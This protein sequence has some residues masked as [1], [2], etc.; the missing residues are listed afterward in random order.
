[1]NMK[2]SI[3]AAIAALGLGFGASAATGDIFS[4]APCD[5]L[6]VNL[7]DPY[8]TYD[9][10]VGA[11][12]EL[13]FKITLGAHKANGE[14][15]RLTYTGLGSEKWDEVYNPLQIGIFVS[16]R[17]QYASL[18][19]FRRGAGDQTTEMV[20][21]YVT[22]SGDFAMPI[23]LAAYDGA[24][25]AAVPVRE[26]MS[27]ASYYYLNPLN[28]DDWKVTFNNS[29]TPA[30]ATETIQCT[31]QPAAVSSFMPPPG[32]RPRLHSDSLASA[33][34]YVKTI[35][36]SD[37]AETPEFWRTI[38]E[39]STI[40]GGGV[41]PKLAIDAAPEVETSVYV[42]S[43]DESA[44]KVKGGRTV[45]M[46]IDTAGTRADVQVGTVTFKGGQVESQDFQLEGS[47]GGE[48]RTANLVLSSYDVFHYS[49]ATGDRIKDYLSV[50]V[51]CIEPLPPSVIVECD[52]NTAYANGNYTTYAAVLQV[53]L[54]QPCVNPVDVKL[55][56]SFTDGTTGDFANYFRFSASDSIDEPSLDGSDYAEPTVTIP[57]GSVGRQTVYL[58]CLRSDIHTIGTAKVKI[59]SSTTSGEIAPE[60][61]GS[62][63]I[64]VSADV[65]SIITPA[66]GSKISTTCNDEY[67]FTLA[68]D[69]TFAD[70]HDATT[71]YKIFVKY[72]A[73][74]TYKQLDGV[75]Y[76]G[77]GNALYKLDMSDPSNPQKSSELP[78]LKYTA[79]GEGLESEVYVVAPINPNTANA[80]KSEVRRFIADVKEAR[81]VQIVAFDA[82][83][84]AEKRSFNEGED[85]GFRITLSEKNET[86][87]PIYAY[88]KPS[89]NVPVDIFSCQ[90]Y[91]CV[92]GMDAPAGLP[93]NNSLDSNEALVSL[94]DGKAKPGLKITFEVMLSTEPN[95]DGTDMTKKLSGYDSNY[96]TI[97]TYNVEPTIKRIELNGNK[98]SYDGFTFANKLPLG[99]EQK[100]QIYVNE[101]GT[102]DLESTTEPFKVRWS[103]TLGGQSYDDPKEIAGDPRLAANVFKY[104]F[105]AAG[106]WK[107][108]AEVKDKDMDDWSELDYSVYVTILDQPALEGPE[109]V[110][111]RENSLSDWKYTVTVPYYDPK[112]TGNLSVIVEVG[113]Y[114]EGKPNPGVLKL[115]AKYRMT[116]ADAQAAIGAAAIPG[117]VYN[118]NRDYYLV[119]L[120]KSKL[121][122][123]LALEELDGTDNSG[124]YGFTVVSHVIN[125][126]V[127]PTSGQQ[128]KKYYLE[129]NTT[130]TWISNVEPELGIVTLENT[131]A[132]KVSG[133]EATSYPIR[134][135]VKKDV[136]ADWEAGVTVEF[137]GCSN[138]ETAKQT[139]HEPTSGVFV[140]KFAEQGDQTVTMTISDK[141]G[142]STTWTYLYFVEPRKALMVRPVGPA[143][144]TESYYDGALGLGKGRVFADGMLDDIQGFSQRWSYGVSTGQALLYAAGYASKTNA[145]G[146]YSPY[147]DDGS[148]GTATPRRDAAIDPH[149]NK[150]VGGNYFTYDAVYDNYFYRWLYIV[151]DAEGGNAEK[152]YGL[153][154]FQRVAGEEAVSPKF[155]LD[156]YEKDK[157]SYMTREV[158][159]IF[160]RENLV[161]D[162]LGDINADGIPD[163][164]MRVYMFDAFNAAGELTGDDLGEHYVDWDDGDYLPTER[165]IRPRNAAGEATTWSTRSENFDP[166]QEIRGYTDER[167]GTMS[168]FNDA[169]QILAAG[170]GSGRPA[171]LMAGISA[172]MC[173]DDPMTNDCSTLSYAEW[174]A[175]RNYCEEKGWDPTDRS[176]WGLQNGSYENSWSPERPTNPNR[177][178][179][180]GDGLSDGF[181]YYIWYHA[182]VGYVD[183]NTNQIRLAGRRY[184]VDHP[185]DPEIISPDRVAEL[186]DPLSKA[187]DIEYRDCDNDGLTDL[188]EFVLGTNP[189]DYDTDGDGIPDGYEIFR[190]GT[191]PLI[192]FDDYRANPDHDAMAYALLTGWNAYPLVTE[193]GVTNGY[194]CT[195]GGMNVTTNDDGTVKSVAGKVYDAWR[196]DGSTF[197]RGRLL[198]NKSLKDARIG[199]KAVSSVVWAIHFDAYLEYGFDPRIGWKYDTLPYASLPSVASYNPPLYTKAFTHLDES[200]V[201]AFYIHMGGF[202]ASDLVFNEDSGITSFWQQ[203]TTDPH[204][205][206][207][208]GDGAP[209]GWELYDQCGPAVNGKAS[210]PSPRAATSPFQGDAVDAD[211]PEGMYQGDEFSGTVSSAEYADCPTITLV[212]PTWLNKKWPTDQWNPDTDGD[213]ISDPQEATAFVYPTGAEGSTSLGCIAGGGL[214]PLSWDTDGDGLPDPWELEFA[215]S[216]TVTTVAVADTNAVASADADGAS[217]SNAVATVSTTAWGG[218]MNGTVNDAMLDY[219]NDGLKNWQEYMVGMMRCWRYDDTLTTWTV[220]QA[221]SDRLTDD[222]YLYRILVDTEGPEYNPLVRS[223]HCSPGVYMSCCNNKWDDNY[224]RFYYFKDGIYHDLMI[225]AQNQTLGYQ[226]RWH[227]KVPFDIAAPFATA[228]TYPTR[229]ICCDPR[230]HDTD[231][232]GMDDFY[233]LFHG[234]NPLL[235]TVDVIFRSWMVPNVPIPWSANNCYW[236]F[237]GE[238]IRPRMDHALRLKGETDSNYDFFQYPWLAGLPTAD[239]DGDNVRNIQEAI[240]SHAQAESTY[241]HT[242]PTPLWMTDT[243][244]PDSLVYRYYLNGDPAWNKGSV[245]FFYH[246]TGMFRHT[247][248]GT[249]GEEV[250]TEYYLNDF[251]W[252]QW[253]QKTGICVID[254]NINFWHALDTMFSY[255]QGEGYDTDGDFLSDFEEAQGKTKSAS[256]PQDFDD[257]LRRQAMYFGGKENPGFLQS[258]LPFSELT[259]GGAMPAS[260]HMFLYYT[261]ECWAKPDASDIGSTDLQTLVERAV[262]TGPANAADESWMR[263]NFLLGLRG[264]RWYTKFDSSGTDRNQPVEIL[265]GPT[266]TTNWTHIAATYDGEALRLYVNGVCQGVQKTSI[267]PEHGISSS[268]VGI[269]GVTRADYTWQDYGARSVLYDTISFVIGADAKAANG[270]APDL[271][272]HARNTSSGVEPYYFNPT[273]AATIDDYTAFFKGYIDEVRVWDGARKAEEILADV[274]SRK[275]YTREDALANREKVQKEINDGHGRTTLRGGDLSAELR[276]HWSF[277][278]VPGAVE[279]GDVVTLPAGF[280]TSEGTTDGMAVWARPSGWITPWLTSISPSIRSTVYTDLAWVPWIRNT[281]SHLPRVD[282]LT[283]DSLFWAD[284]SAGG[285]PAVQNGVPGYDF[286]RQAEP[287][288]VWY[289]MLYAIDGMLFGQDHVTFDGLDYLFAMRESHTEGDDLIPLG[290]VY[291][292]RISA[293]EGGLWDD[294]GAADAWAETRADSDHNCFPDWWEKYA[295]QNLSAK[296]LPWENFKWDT[297]VVFDGLEMP[298]WNAYL[299]GLARGL[300][301]D[302]VYHDGRN[303]TLDYRDTRDVDHDGIL[304][305]WED[306]YG[307]DTRSY[308]D[309]HADYDHDGLSNYAEFLLSEVFDLKR[310]GLPL[311]F[312]PTDPCSVNPEVSDYFY[313]L[314]ELYVGEIFTDH[315]RMD[316]V[317]EQKFFD[318]VSPY[319]YDADG[320]P[321]GDG[322]SNYAEFQAGTDPTMLG[323][324]G[325]DEI[326][327]DEYPVPTIEVSVNYEGNQNVIGKPLVVKAW[328]DPDLATIPDAVWTV[329]QVKETTQNVS[330]ASNNV[331]GVKYIGMNPGRELLFHLSPGSIVKGSV[332]FEYKDVNWYLVDMATGNAWVFDA[333]TAVWQECLYDREISGLPG[334]GEIVDKLTEKVVGTIDYATGSVT[335]DLTA[336]SD[337]MMINGDI[338]QSGTGGDGMMLVSLY[339]LDMS[340]IRVKWNAKPITG[341]KSATYYLS[342]ADDPTAQL[343]SLGHVKEGDNTFIAFYDFDGNGKYTAGEPYG[344]VSGVDVGWNYAKVRIELSDTSAVS[345]RFNTQDGTND[346]E[347]LYGRES[348]NYDPSLV[349]AGTVSGGKY[350]RVRVIRTM[351][352]D[353][354]VTDLD[355]PAAVV[356]D[357]EIYIDDEQLYM[358][359]ADFLKNGRFDLDWDTLA[360]DIAKGK[361][362]GLAINS[363]GYRIVLGNGTVKNNETNN[364]LGLVFRRSFDAKEVYTAASQKPVCIG[365]GIVNSASPTFSW[366]VPNGLNSYTAFEI[367]VYRGGSRVWNSGFQLLPARVRDDRYGWRYDWK[368]P[369]FAGD[370]LVNGSVFEN[371]ANYQWEVRVTNARFRNLANWSVPAEF[372]MNVLT[373]SL[374]YGTVNVA[375]R[376]FGPA[377][378]R[379][380]GVIRV[381]AFETP[382]FSGLPVGQGYVADVS[383]VGS[384]GRISAG[385]ASIIGLPAGN[386]YIRA[387]V[388]TENDGIRQDWE[389]WGCACAR[390]R[391]AGQ[392][393]T[394]RSVQVGPD[395]GASAIVRVYMDD[396]DTDQDHLPDAWEYVVN[397]GS[398][399]GTGVGE[400]DSRLANGIAIKSS[401]ADSLATKNVMG[402]GLSVMTMSALSNPFAAALVCGV[403]VSDGATAEDVSSSLFRAVDSLGEKDTTVMITAISLDAAKRVV[404]IDVAGSLVNAGSSG[405]PL[406]TFE[407]TPGKLYR[408]ELQR[409]NRLDDAEWR[410]VSEVTFT[411]GLNELSI[412]VPVAEGVDCDSAY[413]KLVPAAE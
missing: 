193:A 273:A 205:A 165:S 388:D 307:I 296:L 220:H 98:S 410:K 244:Y 131:N 150:Y 60:N 172:D 393:F 138:A 177:E 316:D 245:S 387:F 148:L 55:T 373:N 337:Y 116:P 214:N 158:E 319:L 169:Y 204:N 303:D 197:A 239:P 360:T 108:T 243:S 19:A 266:A 292:K 121:A 129:S 2:N 179:T 145:I 343:N 344:T 89:V 126:D 45:N 13:Y 155:A 271:A 305:W 352:D 35:D 310:D 225:D 152:T 309:A 382:D 367:N 104:A 68:V 1:M 329:G 120:T 384:Y 330:G 59:S 385:N 229:Y 317:W 91:N 353:Y 279:V 102:Y 299:R 408:F 253:D 133:V 412:D 161:T 36:F 96:L 153:V 248:V 379:S 25:G 323:S 326:Q 109:D 70:T 389:T 406:Y 52:R 185:M 80:K 311:I 340:Y 208:D 306:M 350:E 338:S 320:D 365:P 117:F 190:T 18:V 157:A 3:L 346:R 297:T 123:D 278:H 331:A 170:I 232:D 221:E 247:T 154:N 194:V 260:D 186:F 58:Y 348:G 251:P 176:H 77:D 87:A 304:D 196:Y 61:C 127:L 294:L 200:M 262:W 226:N 246:P 394:P 189:I 147:R 90:T 78:T 282:G 23:L 257:P 9:K 397:H 218:G 258:S 289:Q 195:E 94:L 216:A 15:W 106:V 231:E 28:R 272:W 30:T 139:I 328:H 5:E 101:P 183:A 26:D 128:A 366:Y 322:W 115:D 207:T 215:G 371:D 265:N 10:P 184:R 359:E 363:V 159:A 124:I 409:K 280:N 318:K 49:N 293:T 125:D 217:S 383:E 206:D 151:T 156:A 82:D 6:G 327:I 75:Y 356:L 223:F 308:A 335:I 137:A 267:Q 114:S 288:C 160:S 369:I 88:I 284:D 313:R 146:E 209:D 53:Y 24:D 56:P 135:Q 222:E 201:A 391:D 181:E 22:K 39:G 333:D 7:T 48:N 261:V 358:T 339:N 341:A 298:A 230:N 372:R 97:T 255:E 241:N 57:A 256:N 92:I 166:V 368:A 31:W 407:G 269:D 240:M 268:H 187:G 113:Q 386:Y 392:I 202:E 27:S 144:A 238:L 390:D 107:I 21:R 324:I 73:S 99:Q 174:I 168:H 44:V 287:Q 357:K 336:V 361:T 249:N 182:H 20:F 93:I 37:D 85:V 17:L 302:G 364:L 381:Q 33:G 111:L 140:P 295:R 376:H 67:P 219:D 69:D 227:R 63:S 259:S 334:K 118:A 163:L 276:Y 173:F 105:P 345:P 136:E 400:L 395:V 351:I 398:L 100:F 41:V 29:D 404:H 203:W 132:W 355:V 342:D 228:K 290:G 362:E 301:P 4:I 370:K 235:G 95:W 119:E 210:C 43:D 86:G 315:D 54:S 286:A 74:D 405:M 233:E 285:V 374:D 399:T 149:G 413:F 252:L 84:A 47:V 65:T 38:H 81:T 40:T 162:N 167:T 142:G 236:T 51:K 380:S 354:E 32:A 175:F 103:A 274:R 46:Q 321:D 264:G 401:L 325:I 277:D 141:D 213:G 291:A 191:D 11:G 42:W 143:S 242:D 250:V 71:G 263:K 178:D 270:I 192:G 199:T 211:A 254:N 314:G 164:Y 224:G 122:Q 64:N 347:V 188:E 180:D 66:E 72:R 234:L 275:R 171:P 377:S 79:S 212:S 332:R 300:L 112:Y 312:D 14:Y 134:W 396:C 237:A 402:G 12:R 34:F 62:K 83:F 378:I 349:V 403:P 130:R 76:V 281:I 411:L 375:V 110:T 283:R 198:E 50:K 16:G 8:A